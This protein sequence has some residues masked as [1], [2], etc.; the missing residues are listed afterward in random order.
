MNILQSHGVA[1]GVVETGEDLV[2]RDENYRSHE[3][4]IELPYGKGKAYCEN[5]ML[6]FSDTPCQVRR[7]APDMGEHNNYVYGELLGMSEEEIVQCYVDEV[8]L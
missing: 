8:F 1:A 3:Y 7:A 5:T 2:T 6:G 4:Y